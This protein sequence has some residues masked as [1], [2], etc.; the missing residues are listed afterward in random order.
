MKYIKTNFVYNPCS[1][2]QRHIHELQGSVEKSEPLEKPHKHRFASSSG[3]EVPYGSRDHFHDVI[4]RTDINNNHYHEF[5][6]RTSGAYPIGDKHV[7]FINTLTTESDGHSHSII[8]ST[9]IE[10]TDSD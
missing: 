8:L 1:T 2:I 7:H 10:K 6:G 3:E 4:L 5:C 9:S